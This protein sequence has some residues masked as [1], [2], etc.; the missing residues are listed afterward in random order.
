MA[1]IN[2]IDEYG[3]VIIVPEDEMIVGRHVRMLGDCLRRYAVALE[4]RDASAAIFIITN[5]RDD[6]RVE[7]ETCCR[8]CGVGGIAH[9]FDDFDVFKG[10]FGSKGE[11]EFA[12]SAINSAMEI[13]ILEADESIGGHV[14]DREYVYGLL[15]EH[16]WGTRCEPGYARRSK[17]PIIIA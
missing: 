10:N 7:S 12:F 4:F 8:D 5:I 6:C 13:C 11:T 17:S 9:A 1:V 3:A 14:S 2:M 15:G 16:G